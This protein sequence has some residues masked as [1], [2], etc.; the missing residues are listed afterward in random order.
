MGQQDMKMRKEM[1]S[2]LEKNG[3]YFNQCGTGACKQ[4]ITYIKLYTLCYTPMC[5]K[6]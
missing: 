2:K 3:K 6:T 1:R 5:H 4:L